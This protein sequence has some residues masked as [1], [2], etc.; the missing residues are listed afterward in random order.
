VFPGAFER[1]LGSR[2][3]HSLR[4]QQPRELGATGWYYLLEPCVFVRPS[5]PCRSGQAADRAATTRA[6]SLTGGGGLLAPT[7]CWAYPNP[8][9]TAW[10][11]TRAETVHPVRAKPSLSLRVSSWAAAAGAPSTLAARGFSLKVARWRTPSDGRSRQ[12]VPTAAPYGC[13]FRLWP[14]HPP[15]RFVKPNDHSFSLSRSSVA[16]TWCFSTPT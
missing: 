12:T 8:M 3:R 6:I 14:G 4:F 13:E 1:L 5:R 11:E 7:T 2:A 16:R 15:V 9:S 10:A